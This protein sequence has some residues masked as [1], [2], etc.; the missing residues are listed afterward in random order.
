VRAE[1]AEEYLANSKRRLYEV[2]ELLG[3]SSAGD[4]SR[5]FRSHFGKTP[6]GWAVSYQ[7]SK[8]TPE[9]HRL[10]KP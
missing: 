7:E 2:A 6:S 3:F 1:L 5:W 4:F 9:P 10:S 8:A